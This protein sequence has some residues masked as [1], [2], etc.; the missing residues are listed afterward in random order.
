MNNEQLKKTVLTILRK[1][2]LYLNNLIE[3]IESNVE[4]GF[5]FC[6]RKNL[7]INEKYPDVKYEGQ[8]GQKTVFLTVRM[9]DLWETA[10]VEILQ[11]ELQSISKIEVTPVNDPVG[12]IMLKF[13]DGKEMRWEIKSSQA[14]DSFTGAT[15]SASKCNN[16]ILINYSID[17]DLKLKKGKRNKGFIKDLAVFI[18]DNMEAKWIGDPTKNNSFTSLKIPNEVVTDR[19]EI[20]VVGELEPKRKWCK[21]KRK[22]LI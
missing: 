15:H 7:S 6:C 3:Y 18:W 14:Q 12:D 19:P 22:N 21:I 4:D 9:F 1:P 11:K 16:Y 10:I 5:N 13:P 2:E 20:V 8:L 17:K